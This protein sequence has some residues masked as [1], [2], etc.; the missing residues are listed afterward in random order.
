M[1]SNRIFYIFL[2][3]SPSSLLSQLGM[4]NL[5]LLPSGKTMCGWYVWGA[6]YY[7]PLVF[8]GFQSLQHRG[9]RYNIEISR[10]VMERGLCSSHSQR[11]TV[12]TLSSGSC[13]DAGTREEVRFVLCCGT[14]LA[15]EPGCPWYPWYPWYPG[16]ISDHILLPSLTL[17]R[18]LPL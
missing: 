13:S 8:M 17:A 10:Q 16:S 9:A 11:E 6:N 2:L 1:F 5:F 3:F 14:A 18:A 15:C 12:E 4:K 7:L